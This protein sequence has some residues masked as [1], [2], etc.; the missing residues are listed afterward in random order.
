MTTPVRY[1][2]LGFGHHAAKRLVPAFAACE[3]STLAGLWRR[4]TAA[5]AENALEYGIRHN[6]ASRQELCT[7]PDIDAV[8]IT[9]PDAL[10][11]EDVLLAAA[12][13]KAILCEKPLAMS[14]AEAEAMVS[15]A[16]RA[17]VVFGVAQNFRWNASLVWLREQIASGRI[18]SPQIAHAQFAYRADEAPRQWIMDPALACGGPIGD[19]GV[20]CIDALRFVLGQE[21]VAVETMARTDDLSGA[22]EAYATMQMEM[23]GG[24]LA[25]ATVSARAA[26]RTLVEVVG[27]DATIVIET[28]MTVDRP[29]EAVVLSG[30]GVIERRVF[31]NGD[32]YS[33]MLDDFSRAV[34]GEGSFAASGR[35]GVTNMRI[36]DA[37]YA[38]WREHAA[39]RRV[40]QFPI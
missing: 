33:R 7:S 30:E 6:F 34:R 37:A 11:R 17:G 23:S 22:V 28:G 1:A 16:D 27:H 25:L 36:L 20:H 2:F 39:L 13:G 38:S 15:A 31:D 19:V 3:H 10:H 26:Y 4:N 8:F 12:G 18:G 14:A 32:A 5:G 35:D 24:C 29:V 40:T 21:V 9:S